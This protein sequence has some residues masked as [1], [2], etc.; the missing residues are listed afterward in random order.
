M[1]GTQQVDEDQRVHNL[2]ES[3]S[4]SEPLQ[5]NECVAK[6][7]TRDHSLALDPRVLQGLLAGETL[8]GVNL[9]EIRYEVFGLVTDPRPVLVV[10][11][12]FPRD[13]L[14]SKEG[15]GGGVEGGIATK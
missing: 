8:A 10:K 6:V 9:E 14:V 3:P 15:V 13:Y 7:F 2:F 1:Q 5:L 4:G 12:K 11:L